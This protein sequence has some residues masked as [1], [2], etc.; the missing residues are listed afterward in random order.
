VE[1]SRSIGL[2]GEG[3][4]GIW[5]ERYGLGVRSSSDFEIIF[6]TASLAVEDEI[7]ALRNLTVIQLMLKR[8]AFDPCGTVRGRVVVDAA[9][10]RARS[11]HIG[12]LP[13]QAANVERNTRLTVCAR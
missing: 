6:E 11:V 3:C 13:A 2:E 7:N 12:W 4:T 5:C 8:H 1:T 9:V 10:D